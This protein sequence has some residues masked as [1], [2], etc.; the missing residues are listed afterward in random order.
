[1]LNILLQLMDKGVVTSSGGKEVNGKNIILI[2]TS[3]LGAAAS[4]KAR[5]GFGDNE[6]VS[7]GDDAIKTFFTPEFRNRLDA[8]VPFNKLGQEIVQNIATKFLTEVKV[9]AAE[10]GYKLKWNKSVIKWLSQPGRGF[11]PAMGARPMK[12]AI[13]TSIKKPL[14]RQMLFGDVGKTITIKVANDEIIF[15]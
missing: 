6:N 5:I 15:E 9:S 3:N 10:R 1:V 11:D 4:E 8:I 13:F 2:M 14:A 7:A 12:R